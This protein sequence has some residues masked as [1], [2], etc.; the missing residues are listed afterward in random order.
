MKR[1]RESELENYQIKDIER[2]LKEEEYLNMDARY[3][4]N[5]A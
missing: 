2:C 1:F 3:N 4:Q 5:T